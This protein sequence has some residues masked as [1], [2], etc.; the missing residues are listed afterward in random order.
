MCTF[1][2]TDGAKEMTAGEMMSGKCVYQGVIPGKPVE[3]WGGGTRAAPRSGEGG[4][5]ALEV[6]FSLSL[7][8]QG[9]GSA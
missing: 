7:G 1:G 4:H 5:Q 6:Q 9:R 8:K 2:C 3:G